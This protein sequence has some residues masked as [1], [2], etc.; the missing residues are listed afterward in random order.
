MQCHLCCLSILWVDSEVSRCKGQPRPSVVMVNN[1]GPK[2][3]FATVAQEQMAQKCHWAFYPAAVLNE[4]YSS[5]GRNSALYLKQGL[6]LRPC[7]RQPLDVKTWLPLRLWLPAQWIPLE[8][9]GTVG[10]HWQC[11]TH[12]GPNTGVDWCTPQ[13]G[14][15]WHS[16]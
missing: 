3:I 8:K 13:W 12:S 6:N 7:T 1:N 14:E 5:L 10:R 2:P 15:S 4:D 9:D 11:K 16:F